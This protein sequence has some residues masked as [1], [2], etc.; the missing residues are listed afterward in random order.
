MRALLDP[1]SHLF[2][3]ARRGERS[4]P[5]L[6]A[7]ALFFVFI[8][9]GG[10]PG[11]VFYVIL[12][13]ASPV[14]APADPP[15][16][17]AAVQLAGILAL[18]FA[19]VILLGWA[20]VALYERRPFRTIGL[21]PPGAV[22]KFLRG[23]A[24]G[25]GLFT[26]VVSLMLLPGYVTWDTADPP[27]PGLAALGGVLIVLLGWLVQGAAEEVLARGWL[28]PVV[29]AR[30]G[31][32]L[33]VLLSAA[34]FAL[35]HSLNSDFSPLAAA[36]ICLVGLLFACYALWEGGI[37][38]VCGLHVAW[39]WAQGNL[40]G[41]Q[42]SGLGVSAGALLDLR[43]T[44]PG[45]ITGDAFGPEGGLAATA[46][47]LSALTWFGRALWRRPPRPRSEIA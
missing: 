38:G 44:G 31:P 8:L 14:D 40:F 37:W 23:M 9:I 29:G 15:P 5:V 47:I 34:V 2:A 1:N 26:L 20:W 28:M 36:N 30:Y 22:W 18:S 42:V 32:W 46:V 6:L 19:G 25:L 33:G 12:L 13:L 3:L 21:E 35:A 10:I 11:T 4:T 7:I 16:L 43:Q 27:R 17:L 24:I 39:N 45:L 41:F